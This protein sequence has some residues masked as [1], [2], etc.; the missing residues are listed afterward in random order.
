MEA[1]SIIESL[2]A[3][4]KW[5]KQHTEQFP[6]RTTWAVK[7]HTA[8]AATAGAFVKD[9]ISRDELALAEKRLEA[10]EEWYGEAWASKF[11]AS[12]EQR[13][14]AMAAEAAKIETLS[15]KR[16]NMRLGWKM[17]ENGGVYDT[18]VFK[19]YTASCRRYG[20]MM[21]QRFYAGLDIACVNEQM[22][23][24]TCDRIGGRLR[25]GSCYVG[26]LLVP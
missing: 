13:R 23:R 20:E 1:D 11:R 12:V 15:E 18:S 14:A 4:A 21:G 9:A 16:Y 5:L 26:K 3:A 6:D 17:M 19:S 7:Q 8:A 2:V 22:E 10:L 25:D 24:Y